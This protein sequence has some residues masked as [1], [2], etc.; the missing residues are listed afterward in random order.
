MHLMELMLGRQSRGTT[1]Y[2]ERRQPVVNFRLMVP[3]KLTLLLSRW[4]LLWR[5]R[6]SWN[7][8]GRR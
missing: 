6:R 5:L 3:W 4:L 2:G 8:C 1:G 7:R